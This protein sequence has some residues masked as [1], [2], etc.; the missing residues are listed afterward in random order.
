MTE[1]LAGQDTHV[2]AGWG[3]EAEPDISPQS[4]TCL[5]LNKCYCPVETP[6]PVG[7]GLGGTPPRPSP[8]SLWRKMVG[9]VGTGQ[10]QSKR[11]GSL[12]LPSVSYMEIYIHTSG[13]QAQRTQQAL[14]LRHKCTV[15]QNLGASR[16]KPVQ[17]TP[18]TWPASETQTPTEPPE[19]TSGVDTVPL[20]T[21]QGHYSAVYLL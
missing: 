9:R 7:S 5:P 12:G 18:F 14:R 3:T 10:G 15:S 6:V 17:V 1:T 21:E 13:C 16:T 11:E 8:Q 19:D 2:P 20:N 4:M